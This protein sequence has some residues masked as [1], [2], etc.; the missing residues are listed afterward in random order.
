M[1]DLFYEKKPNF[2]GSYKTAPKNLQQDA[3]AQMLAKF[4]RI[5]Q[6]KPATS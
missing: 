6:E 1:Y 3:N 2:A 4:I 5:L